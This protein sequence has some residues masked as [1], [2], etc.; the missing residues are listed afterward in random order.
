[1]DTSLNYWNEPE[2]GQAVRDSGLDR[3]KVF[4]T[5]K[6]EGEYQGRDRTVEGFLRSLGNLGIGYVD[7]YLVH[8]PVRGLG[9][10]TW[11]AMEDLLESGR[12][13]AIGVS[14]YEVTHLEELLKH[15]R[16]VPAI[17]Q[18]ELHPFHYARDVVTFCQ[19]HGIQVESYSPLGQ[20]EDLSDPVIAR[21]AQAHGRTPAQVVLR[22]HLQH[23]FIPIPRSADRVHIA[24]NFQVFDFALSGKEMQELDAL[25]RSAVSRDA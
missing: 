24:E 12:C 1:V 18:I 20:G 16:I 5:S 9:I 10:E 25:D 13:R 15:G 7:L 21:V 19:D 2:V 14:N 8:W 11:K 23:R 22:W 3:E 6:L 17:N 4:V